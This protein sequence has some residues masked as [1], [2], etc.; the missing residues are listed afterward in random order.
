MDIYYF[1]G[2]PNKSVYL[3][4]SNADITV[5]Q[6]VS[7]LGYQTVET[8][9]FTK[10][11]T[12]TPNEVNKW[13]QVNQLLSQLNTR[14]SNNNKQGALSTLSNLNDILTDIYNEANPSKK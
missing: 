3:V 7:D 9:F 12:Q 5:I 4:Y 10:N 13:Q 6:K 14:I 11:F 2:N 1:K 8:S